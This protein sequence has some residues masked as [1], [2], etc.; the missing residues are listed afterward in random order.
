MS[1]YLS[2]L[3]FFVSVYLSVSPFLFP[4][5]PLSLSV[6]LYVC[7]CAKIRRKPQIIQRWSYA[8]LIG[9]LVCYVGNGFKF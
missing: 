9:V 3:W 7:S 8:Q 6:P 4:P 2:P 5:S 1:P